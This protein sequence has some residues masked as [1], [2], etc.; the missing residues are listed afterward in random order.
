MIDWE[1]QWRLFAPNFYD[2]CAHIPLSNGE[3]IR[4]KPGEGF[5][6]LSHP[7]TQLMLKL[8]SSR[9]QNKIVVD[10]GCGSGILSIAAAKLGAKKVYGIDI[11]PQ[12]LAHAKKN[13]EFNHCHK[14]VFIR[15]TLPAEVFHTPTVILMNMIMNEQKCAWKSNQQLHSE[16][17]IASGI[18]TEQKQAYL[19]LVKSWGW[20]RPEKICTKS[21]WL[22]FL[23]FEMS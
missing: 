10:I 12:A 14:R 17:I 15:K 23:F 16:C 19:E 7:T 11:D 4:L 3:E 20:P 1:E 18:L 13:C 21:G 8:M 6:D 2:G 5:G 22:G 9:V